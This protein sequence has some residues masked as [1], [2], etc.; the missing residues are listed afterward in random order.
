[1]RRAALLT[2][3]LA[4][5]CTV[6]CAAEPAAPE[7]PFAAG[8]GL[9]PSRVE[10]DSPALRRQKAAAGVEPCP[11]T[12][13]DATVREGGLPAVTLPCLGGGRPVHLAGLPGEPAVVNLWAS[14]CTPCREELPVLQRFHERARG[15]VLMLGVDFEDTRPGAALQLLEET[16]V[17]YPQVADLDKAI[18]QGDGGLGRHPLPLTVLVDATGQ[19]VAKLPMQV[20]SVEQLAGLVRQHLGVTV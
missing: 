1:V 17:T 12:D 4:V 8:S 6:G 18:D 11:R 13:A 19:V 15:K 16:G 3:T 14:W 10:V 7:D 5:L 9:T 20:T 2:A